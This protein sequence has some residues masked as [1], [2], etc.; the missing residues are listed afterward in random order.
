M[1]RIKAIYR[2]RAIAT[3]EVSVYRAS[4]RK[5]W[6]AKLE[7]GA[8][9]RAASLL[10]QL[11]GLLELRPKAKAAMIVAA[12]RQSGW[13]VLRSIPFLGAVRVAQLLVIMRT[14]FRF[15]TKRNLWP[16]AGLAVVKHSGAN[17]VFQNGKLQRS[18]RRR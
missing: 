9:V 15:R 3:P 6:L 2:A 1:Q 5:Q 18:K 4:Q 16:Y 14:P 12:R 17:Q 11:D 7:G 13:K 8:R 10:T